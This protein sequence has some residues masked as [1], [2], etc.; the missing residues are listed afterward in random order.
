MVNLLTIV[1][2]LVV[3]HT[4]GKL[5]AA[6][7]SEVSTVA[8]PAREALIAD[9]H[10]AR[11]EAGYADAENAVSKGMAADGS[12]P[13]LYLLR[14]ILLDRENPKP[15]GTQEA[16]RRALELDENSAEAHED[17][18]LYLRGAKHFTEAVA[19]VSKGLKLDPSS[20]I[21]NVYAGWIL[22]SV[23]KEN[24]AVSLFQRALT[25]SPDYPSA[26]YFLAR[27]AEMHGR[28][29]E[30]MARLE[31][32]ATS[33]DRAPKYLHALG[34]VDAEAGK[35]D[36][37]CRVLEELRQQAKRRY[38]DPDYITSLESK[39]IAMSHR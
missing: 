29:N 38:V 4:I 11:P 16:Y 27:V 1:L 36:E 8:L 10:F 23:G 9:Y 20:A 37:G 7:A 21:A 17:Y 31:L 39:I 19:E 30:A 33:S 35:K 15:A 32:A 13:E 24:D 6:L 12:I 34:M 22:L 25:L 28:H 18:A 26:L 14:A 5:T 3:R 2:F